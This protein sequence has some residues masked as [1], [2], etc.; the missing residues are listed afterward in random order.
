MDEK[1]GGAA[2]FDGS[3]GGE[4]MVKVCSKLRKG[5]GEALVKEFEIHCFILSVTSYELSVT[6]YG[7]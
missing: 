3:V 6:S 1:V 4:G 5:L 7:I 2:D